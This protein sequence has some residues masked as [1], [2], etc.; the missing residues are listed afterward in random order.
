MKKANGLKAIGIT[1]M[2]SKFRNGID[3][4][5]FIMFWKVTEIRDKISQFDDIENTDSR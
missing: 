5:Y 1:M 2:K 3:Y 4:R